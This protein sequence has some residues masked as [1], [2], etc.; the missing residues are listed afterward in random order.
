MWQ[1]WAWWKECWLKRLCPAIWCV[2]SCDVQL[3]MNGMGDVLATLHPQP[4]SMQ[5]CLSPCNYTVKKVLKRE[6]PRHLQ[7]HYPWPYQ[8]LNDSH[9]FVRCYGY[10]CVMLTLRYWEYYST[11]G[12]LYVCSQSQAPIL[13]PHQVTNRTWTSPVKMICSSRQHNRS[14]RQQ[15]LVLGIPAWI[16]QQMFDCRRQYGC[17]EQWF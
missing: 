3:L 11:Y 14:S 13:L 7:G 16:K 6:K 10:I 9:K 12:P 4:L 2:R 15:P 8:A 17:L 5:S 1:M